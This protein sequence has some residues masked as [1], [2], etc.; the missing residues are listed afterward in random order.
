RLSNTERGLPATAM[1]Q[2]YQSC[3]VPILDYGVEVWWNG[4]V[5]LASKLQVLQ[6]QGTRVILGA[7]KSTPALLLDVEA[8]VLPTHQ[9]LDLKKRLLALR[10]LR[11]DPYH[12]LRK[13]CP[14]SF[15]NNSEVGV[16][17]EELGGCIWDEEERQR[18]K[19]ST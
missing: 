4:Q 14:K 2:L 11:L 10:I 1:R 9:R 13:R 18:S 17:D 5:G 12:P 7:F 15:P 19:Y 3:V 8:A 6:N 16:D